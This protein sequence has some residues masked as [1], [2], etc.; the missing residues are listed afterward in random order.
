[1]LGNQPG[2][3]SY[4]LSVGYSQQLYRLLFISTKAVMF[5]P[6]FVSRLLVSWLDGMLVRRITQKVLDRCSQSL[7]GGG[8][9]YKS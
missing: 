2:D 3:V 1:M 8:F 4:R 9:E 5:L 7:R 6:Q